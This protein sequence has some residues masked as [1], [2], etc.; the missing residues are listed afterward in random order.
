MDVIKYKFRQTGEHYV[1]QGGEIVERPQG[2]Y[3]APV[4]IS[5]EGYWMFDLLEYAVLKAWCVSNFSGIWEINVYEIYVNDIQDLM[6]F[7][8]CHN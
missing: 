2:W 3:I 1:Y 8:L 5:K 6:L 7:Q 4:Q